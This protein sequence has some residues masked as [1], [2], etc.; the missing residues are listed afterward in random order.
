MGEKVLAPL[1]VLRG[2][3]KVIL[4]DH[5]KLLKYAQVLKSLMELPRR[6]PALCSAS[7]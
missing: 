1:A 4:E 5:A 3:R 6:C 2:V 7:W